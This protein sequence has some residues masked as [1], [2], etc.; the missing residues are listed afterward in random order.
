MVKGKAKHSLASLLNKYFRSA[1]GVHPVTKKNALAVLNEYLAERSYVD[2]YQMS[3][4]DFKV[5]NSLSRGGYTVELESHPHIRRWRA[6]VK[7]YTYDFLCKQKVN[8]WSLAS[9]L[10]RIF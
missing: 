6:H 2:G 10:L 5:S 7:S 3:N 9:L 8:G 1:Y 4:R